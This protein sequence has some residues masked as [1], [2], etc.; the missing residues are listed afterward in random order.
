MYAQVVVLTY[1]PP[2]VDS[3]TY[4]IPKDFDLKIGQLVEV[5]FGKR[6]PSGIVIAVSNKI[7]DFGFRISDLKQISKILIKDPLLLPYQINLLTW[8]SAYYLAPM[9]NCIET[10]LPKIPGPKARLW[11]VSNKKPGFFPYQSLIL[12]PSINRIAETLAKFPKAKNH[13]VYHTELKAS[14]KFATWQKILNGEVDC[15]FGS[16]MAIFTPCPNLK[17]IIIYN[18]H[19]GAYKD[20]RSPYFDTLAVAQKICE[21]TGAKLKIVDPSPKITTY[22]QIPN[23]IKIQTF[24]QQVKT[25][26]MQNEKNSGNRGAISFALEE[27][28]NQVQEA[29]GNVLL[30][31]NKKKETGNLFCKNCKNR[32]FLE[33]KPTTC[34]NCK[35]TD[36]FWNSLNINSLSKEVEKLFGK[37]QIEIGTAIALY[38]QQ[39]KK[40]D[41]VAHI[42]TDSL[43][44]I[45]DYTS[46]EKLFAQITQLKKLLKASGK[47][48]LQSYNV[49]NPTI[50]AAENG[51]FRN[52]YES[53]IKQRKLLS[54][55]PYSMLIKLTIKGKSEEKVKQQAETLLE[56][57]RLTINDSQL[58]ILGPYKSV[59]WKK[60]PTYHIILK[61]KIDNYSLGSRSKIV[62]D[63]SKQLEKGSK[64]Y[65]IEVE[66]DSIQ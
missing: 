40:Y 44:N 46:G 22:A 66:P 8:M 26:N 33:T 27:E 31:L 25:I 48:I 15:V 51:H 29:N 52:F 23:R 55:P 45:A 42:Q 32:Q 9:V 38:A 1:Q 56:N 24:P 13:I 14:E 60:T 21:L 63:L 5:P 20:E 3:Y 57:L 61:H 10:I 53:E 28:I 39:I 50:V 7:S 35:S 37:S 65:T 11:S 19:D 4:E 34:P 49:E 47:L 2:S 6:K 62:E 54:Y 17:E 12:V 30:F 64:N 58:T 43:L 36:F 59:F 16:R 41:L 18:E